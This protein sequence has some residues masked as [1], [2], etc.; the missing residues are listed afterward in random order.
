MSKSNIV[1]ETIRRLCV[2]RR[3]KMGRRSHFP[4]LKTLAVASTTDDVIDGECVSVPYSKA[5]YV[6]LFQACR[7]IMNRN[8][9]WKYTVRKMAAGVGGNKSETAVAWRIR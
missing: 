5:N 3:G 8:P 1:R 9:G 7:S 6:K 4:S 2:S